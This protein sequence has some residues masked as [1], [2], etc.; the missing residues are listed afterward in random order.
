MNK[1]KTITTPGEQQ[2]DLA[3]IRRNLTDKNRGFHVLKG[4]Y[5]TTEARWLREDCAAFLAAGPIRHTRINTDSIEDYVHPRS[6]DERSRTQRVYRY[7]HNHKTDQ[8]GQLLSRALLLRA[9]IES[10]WNGDA[11]YA[12]ERQV[13]Q[14]YVIFTAYHAGSGMLPKHQD[15]NGPALFPLVQFWVLLSNPTH[16]YAGGNLIV[17]SPDGQAYAVER[18]LGL[19]QGDALIFDKSLSHEVE[20]TLA[21]SADGAGRWT[22]LIG[23][24]A[25]RDGALKAA[26]K[27]LLFAPALYPLTQRVQQL[28]GRTPNTR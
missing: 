15:Y 13:L 21:G 10:K 8:V 7:L 17:H 20:L 18:E 4:F 28:L 27:R 9:E 22:V 6:H 5:S 12:R 11:T 2:F 1:H 19:E 14:D 26:T 25:P 16:D 24:R 3:E 23:A